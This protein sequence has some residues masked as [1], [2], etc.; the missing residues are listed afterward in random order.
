MCPP[1]LIIKFLLNE[2][3]EHFLHCPVGKGIVL[4]VNEHLLHVKNALLETAWRWRD[5]GQALHISEGTLESIRKLHNDKDRLDEV[6]SKWM[7]SGEATI[8]RLLEALVDPSVDRNDIA[9]K[10]RDLKGDKR[11]KVGLE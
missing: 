3:T 10:I 9:I 7:H 8:D 6:L 1:R 2:L 11:K 4:D 5:I